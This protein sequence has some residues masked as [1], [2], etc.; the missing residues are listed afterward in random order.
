MKEIFAVQD[1]KGEMF[2]DPF[3]A[4]NVPFAIRRF[5]HEVNKEDHPYNVWPEDFI[6]FR[7]GKYEE[8]TGV[9]LS[10]DVPVAVVRAT[11]VMARPQL[12]EDEEKHA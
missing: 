11:D 5:T 9:I 1:T 12:L 3:Y 6:L 8:T 2:G 4:P 10:E 7:L